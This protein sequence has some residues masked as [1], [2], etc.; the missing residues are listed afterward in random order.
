MWLKCLSFAFHKTWALFSRC[1]CMMN[2]G[3]CSVLLNLVLFSAGC[4]EGVSRVFCVSCLLC[5]SSELPCGANC[6]SS[7][8]EEGHLIDSEW[9]GCLVYQHSA[10]KC[11]PWEDKIVVRCQQWAVVYFYSSRK[12]YMVYA[13]FTSN[14]CELSSL[15]CAHGTVGFYWKLFVSSVENVAW[16]YLTG[17]ILCSLFPGDGGH[18]Y[19]KEGL[20]WAGMILSE[21]TW[22]DVKF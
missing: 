17:G 7:V 8:F 21:L 11:I 19:L 1:W 5:M 13:L 18:G 9:P 22:L 6:F 3:A 20:W 14:G 15:H 2:E 16:S 10:F 4:Q 12:H